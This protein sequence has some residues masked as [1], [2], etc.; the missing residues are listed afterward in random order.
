MKSKKSRD[1]L[2]K[3][4]LFLTAIIWGS[5]FFIVK[6]NIDIFSPFL[7]MAVRFTA[8]FAIMAAI[9]CKKMVNVNV[10]YIKS[11]LIAGSFLFLANAAQTVGIVTTTPGKNAF[12]TTIYCVLVPFFYRL[13][14]GRETTLKNYAAGFICTIGIGAVSLN[15]DLTIVKGDIYTIL[16]GILY[17]G[18]I[19]SIAKLGKKRDMV[20]LTALQFGTAAVFSWAV[21]LS[22]ETWPAEISRDCIISLVYLSVVA[23]TAGF[24]LQNIGQKHTNP[25]A[26]AIILSLES[27]FGML[28]SVIFTGEEITA[29]LAVGFFLIFAA[30]LLSESGSASCSSKGIAG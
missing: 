18:H 20:L 16:S 26:A 23:T 9:F 22:Y 13:V 12:L 11:G 21:G 7:L 4:A 5:S 24:F 3:C 6:N 30:V 2:S 14:D 1:I 15:G 25:S 27:V 29:R 19:V 10:D 8:A 17:A 28:F